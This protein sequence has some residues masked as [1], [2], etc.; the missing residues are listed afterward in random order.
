MP[1]RS[2]SE[3]R[4]E[5][6]PPGTPERRQYDYLKRRYGRIMRITGPV[7]LALVRIPPRWIT[8]RDDEYGMH[9]YAGVGPVVAQFWSDILDGLLQKFEARR[10]P[11]SGHELGNI[12]YSALDGLAWRFFNDEYVPTWSDV[13]AGRSGRH[14][15]VWRLRRKHA[16]EQAEA[17]AED[18]LAE[19]RASP[20][21]DDARNG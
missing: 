5:R 7:Y 10:D 9:N 19:L 17:R 15:L 21:T 16:I 12:F 20:L 18:A 4:D 13:K 11:T 14:R 1:L 6:Y 8:V 3:W 2:L